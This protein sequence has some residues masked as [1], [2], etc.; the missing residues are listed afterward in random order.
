MKKKILVMLM[1]LLLPAMSAVAANVAWAAHVSGT[2]TGDKIYFGYGS[3]PKVG[4]KYNNTN[5]TKVTKVWTGTDV[6]GTWTQVKWMGTATHYEILPSFS[7]VR[8]KS[9]PY[10]FSNAEGI[11]GLEYLNTSET[12]DM[13]R[14]FGGAT[15]TSLN[16][17]NFNTSKVTDMRLMFANCTNL[18]TLDVS[19][20]NVE[21]VKDMSNMFAG[22]KNLTTLD[23]SKWNVGKV[24]SMGH[25]FSECESLTSLDVSKWDV[26]N[27]ESFEGMF[28]YCK[29]LTSL[30]VGNWNTSK[31][32]N[33]SKMF[34]GCVKLTSL[35]LS[36]WNMSW[37]WKVES[38]FENCSSLTSL[39]LKNWNLART[40]TV[41]RLFRNLS[42]LTTLDVSNWNVENVTDMG[43]MF[44]GCTSLTTLDVSSWKVKNV[45]SMDGMF[46]GCAN[47]KSLN[48]LNLV[49]DNVTTMDYMFYGCSSLTSLQLVSFNT[50]KVKSMKQMF[51]NCMSLHTINVGDNWSTDA[52]TTSNDM[53]YNCPA[54]VGESGTI[55]DANHITAE[56]ACIDNPDGSKPGYLSSNSFRTL[57]TI[58]P[59]IN[60]NAQYYVEDWQNHV[61][62]MGMGKEGKRAFDEPSHAFDVAT[63]PATVEYQNQTWTV[64]G[65]NDYAFKNQLWLKKVKLAEGMTYVG[66]QAFIGSGLESAELPSTLTTVSK[67]AFYET[68]NAETGS[69][70]IPTSLADIGEQAFESSKWAKVSIDG[71]KVLAGLF[72]NAT[73][74]SLDLS[75]VK[76]IGDYAF[77]NAQIPSELDFSNMQ[78]IGKQAFEN[79]SIGSVTLGIKYNVT[80]G[81]GAFQNCAQLA[82]VAFEGKQ[83]SADEGAFA[84]CSNL[85][86]LTFA[87][88]CPLQ[89]IGAESFMNCPLSGQTIIFP[90]RLVFIKERAFKGCQFAKGFHFREGLQD[91]SEEAFLSTDA[92]HYADFEKPEP[93]V[94]PSTL[95][96]LGRNAF[97][98]EPI[99][100]ITDGQSVSL[101][102]FNCS[103]N[104]LYVRDNVTISSGTAKKIKMPVVGETITIGA[105]TY[106]VTGN[107]DYCGDWQ[108]EE[109]DGANVCIPAT[110]EGAV[111]AGGEIAYR[112]NWDEGYYLRTNV[113]KIRT[114]AYASCTKLKALQVGAE[115]IES[116]AFYGCDNVE[117]I[118]LGSQVKEVAGDAFDKCDWVL[119]LLMRRDNPE[120]LTWTDY[121]KS[122]YAEEPPTVYVDKQYLDAWKAKF[123][124]WFDHFDDIASLNLGK[125]EI[126][127]IDDNDGHSTGISSARIETVGQTS[128][129]YTIGGQRLNGKPTKPGLYINNGKKVVIK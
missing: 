92:P 17:K 56:Y 23:V 53:F 74:G 4:N 45:T 121:Q 89:Y 3:A 101:S 30:D 18:T 66:Q 87:D 39:N 127:Y 25:M 57:I 105:K 48:L 126:T 11:T 10:M 120:G 97:G 100:V 75:A 55:F 49:T 110:T 104:N 1:A 65:I 31:V 117:E 124:A 59:R 46:Y 116:H 42:N 112:L 8:M 111:K 70:N 5:G 81:M 21:K 47:L 44:L 15:V 94:V 106:S 43:G 14:M 54:L 29:S 76:T 9:C 20:W 88:N 38:M 115:T 83:S 79:S 22:C 72:R 86:T 13:F 2:D 93:V 37:V 33:M 34:S 24:T 35:D 7:S 103:S 16:L 109:G 123:P 118:E 114:N 28:N 50:K 51:Y 69:I 12:T 6:T 77:Q 27:V 82:K 60:V 90:K 113:K 125:E 84:S 73:I 19:N 129:W 98:Q 58:A 95:K 108:L 107:G 63:L 36:G 128:T 78:A 26:S 99:L 91:I 68:G 61:V 71:D 32:W 102:D 67:Q 62:L 96:I 52:V 119:R 80:L 40:E 64:R 41:E 85:Q 122:F